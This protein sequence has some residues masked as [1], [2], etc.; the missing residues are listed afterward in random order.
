MF[1]QNKMHTP[2]KTGKRK[3]IDH[4]YAICNPF[5][6]DYLLDSCIKI[7]EMNFDN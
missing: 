6:H 3:E 1:I 2:F 4:W 7:T 5:T